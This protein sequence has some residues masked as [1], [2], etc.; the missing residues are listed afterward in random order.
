[1][2]ELKHRFSTG[3]G[4]DLVWAQRES[5]LKEVN[6]V[7]LLEVQ[8]KQVG[9]FQAEPIGWA[10]GVSTLGGSSIKVITGVIPFCWMGQQWLALLLVI[11]KH[12]R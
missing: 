3:L 10:L 9:E 2:R 6:W 4:E 12:S 8:V 11:R 1:M 7:C 5:R